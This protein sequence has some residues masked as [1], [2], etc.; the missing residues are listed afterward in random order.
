M[1]R[2]WLS[3]II[4]FCLNNC[5]ITLSHALFL[6][7]KMLFSFT[8]SSYYRFHCYQQLSS[9]CMYYHSKELA[10]HFAIAIYRLCLFAQYWPLKIFTVILPL[11][12]EN[13]TLLICFAFCL[14]YSGGFGDV[15]IFVGW[16]PTKEMQPQAYGTILTHCSNIQR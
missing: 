8:S 10:P 15:R 7:M 2:N 5:S 1:N 3:K 14:L 13:I 4:I 9:Y 16:K 11:L 6:N 12:E